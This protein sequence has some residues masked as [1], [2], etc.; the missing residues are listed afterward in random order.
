[1]ENP[2]VTIGLPILNGEEFI[3]R[4]IESILSQS[5]T[6]FQ[7]IISNNAS[8]DNSLI[9]CEEFAKKDSRIKIFSQK[10]TII[11]EKNFAFVLEKA[12]SKYFVWTSVDDL[13]EETFL[14]KNFQVLENNSKLVCCSG[15][16]ERFGDEIDLKVNQDDSFLKKMYKRIRM[17]FRPF[18]NLSFSGEYIEKASKC[19]KYNN[20]L[21]LFGLFRT[22]IIKKSVIDYHVHSSDLIMCLKVLEFGDVKILDEVTWKFYAR[23]ISSI[24]T[25]NNFKV[26]QGSYL[27]IFFPFYQLTVWCI[28]HFGWKFILKNL[29]HLVWLN[30]IFGFTPLLLDIMRFRK[31]RK[32]SEFERYNYKI[33]NLK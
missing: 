29:K 9:M 21:F 19:L 14:E 10:E 18:Y 30:T 22:E 15:K 1:M 8:T 32:G 20:M 23:G 26:K 33:N 31:K 6:D 28:H 2:I 25:W 16:V 11:A 24:G 5:F 12:E 3:E 13:W 7:I 17:N 4:R 27:E